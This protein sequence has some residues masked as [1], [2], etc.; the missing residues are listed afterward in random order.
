MMGSVGAPEIIVLFVLACLFA[1]YMLPTIVAYFRKK[2]NTPA[3]VLVNL[4]LGWSVIGWIVA[5]VWAV[6][7]ESVDMAPAVATPGASAPTSHGSPILCAHC[8]KYS[9][10]G[11]KFCSHCVGSLV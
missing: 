6:A 1:L 7:T 3:I 10:P 11:S 8:G 4:L 9:N 5:M 2:R